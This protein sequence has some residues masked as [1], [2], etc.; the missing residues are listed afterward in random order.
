MISWYI[1]C[2]YHD[3]SCIY[4]TSIYHV[5]VKTWYEHTHCITKVIRRQPPASYHVPYIM[6]Y[7]HDIMYI[8]WAYWYMT[9]YE[10]YARAWY[11]I[12]R[13]HDTSCVICYD[14]C[15]ISTCSNTLTH[16]S[17]IRT[18]THWYADTF[19]GIPDTLW[20]A[21]KTMWYHLPDLRSSVSFLVI[22]SHTRGSI[23]GQGDRG[24]LLEP[25]SDTKP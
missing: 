24:W 8:S 4:H 20:Y 15:V 6:I 9:I 5:K 16:H 21:Q 3:I 14:I 18:D 10:W 13:P 17:M 19:L 7:H 22:F 11:G 25:F 23:C 2:I 12:E 1:S